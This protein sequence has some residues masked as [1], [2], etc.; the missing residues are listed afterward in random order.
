MEGDVTIMVRMRAD[1]ALEEVADPV[2]ATEYGDIAYFI[3]DN[4]TSL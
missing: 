2:D 3:G 1:G 4:R